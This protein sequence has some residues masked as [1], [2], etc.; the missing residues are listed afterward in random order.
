MQRCVLGG[1][2][3]HGLAV[4]R[5]CLPRALPGPAERHTRVS[6]AATGAKACG[7]A[8]SLEYQAGLFQTVV[9]LVYTLTLFI[10]GI[11]PSNYG[12]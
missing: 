2:E 6:E 11:F 7:R 8:I 5:T 1:A 3:G 10:W 9:L 4:L 12:K